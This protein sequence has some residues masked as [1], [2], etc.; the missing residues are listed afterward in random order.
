MPSEAEIYAK[1]ADQYERL[2]SREDYQS[3]ILTALQRIIP[4]KG[5]EEIETG[6]GT[7]QLTHRVV[8]F[9]HPI[10]VLDT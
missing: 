10:L 9:A 1:H 8:P 6:A 3:N 2:A 4:L 5:L 7:S